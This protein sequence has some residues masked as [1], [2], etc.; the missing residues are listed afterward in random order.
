MR[1][2]KILLIA[3]FISGLDSKCFQPNIIKLPDGKIRGHTLKSA[4]G[5][6][7]YAYQEIPYAA[8]PIGN[9][10]FAEPE[11]PEPWKGILNATKNT[12]VCMQTKPSPGG[13]ETTEDCLYLNVYTPLKSTGKKLDLLPVVVYVHGGVFLFE[14]GGIQYYDPKYLMDY[15]IVAVMIN[16][17]LGALGF[18][19]TYDGTIPGN[20]GLKDTLMALR[21]VNKNIAKFGGDKTRV[22]LMGSSSGA[23]SLSY[24]QQSKLA[25]DLA[26]GYILDCGTSFSTISYQNDPDHYAFK[27]ARM[28]D[29]NFTSNSTRDLLEFLRRRPAEDLLYSP[30]YSD[31]YNVTISLGFVWLP[32]IEDS[33]YE[34][35]LI[36]K[37]MVE[38]YMKGDFQKAPILIGTAN[39]EII[40]ITPE[41]T[42]FFS[43]VKRYD[44]S[45]KE[46]INPYLNVSEEDREQA[47]KEYKLIYTDGKFED[48]IDAFM[49]FVSEDELSTP[50]I[51]YATLV[52]EHAPAYFWQFSY[53][54]LMGGGYQTIPYAGH[55]E[56]LFYLFAGVYAFNGD[57][58]IYPKEDQLNMARVLKIWTNFIKYQNPT[59]EPD[60][61]LNGIIWP[62]FSS[63]RSEYVDI[64]RNLTIRRNPKNYKK[65]KA[66]FDKYARP[67]YYIY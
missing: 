21:W 22:T 6:T 64:D 39:K 53:R 12:K 10:R 38:S 15:D 52:S 13:I 7:F 40:N 37:P 1:W 54:G 2:C 16:Y 20:L 28:L 43:E 63:D 18:L 23:M 49:S 60:E 4:K 56:N 36:T 31:T 25:T 9:R 46:L 45:Y 42:V 41:P 17:R 33:S 3:S 50:I 58:A 14:A 55:A 67:P 26:R 44:S 27:L 61:L 32:S 66:V 8:P 65:V 35:A 30:I 48:D 5:K 11:E 24:L 34:K 47:G 29:K 57:P 62:K 59:P 51:H 19:A